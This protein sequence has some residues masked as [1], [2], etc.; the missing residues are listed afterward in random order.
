MQ[1]PSADT[2]DALGMN[3]SPLIRQPKNSRLACVVGS[4]RGNL[5]WTSGFVQAT[6]V[7]MVDAMNKEDKHARYR[8]ECCDIRAAVRCIKLRQ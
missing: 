1:F 6:N 3:G 2:L 7:A 5:S 8:P 4:G